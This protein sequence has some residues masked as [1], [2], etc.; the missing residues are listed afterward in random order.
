[1]K[2]GTKL[3]AMRLEGPG[4]L[5]VVPSEIHECVQNA[6]WLVFP[7]VRARAV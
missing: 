5:P 3:L 7:Q 6:R 4:A 1:M 2:L